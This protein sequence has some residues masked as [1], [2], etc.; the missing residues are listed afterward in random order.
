MR[1]Q[2]LEGVSPPVV[3]VAEMDPGRSAFCPW[4]VLGL[5]YLAPVIRIS[6]MW[7]DG[8]NSVE[9]SGASGLLDT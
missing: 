3:C 4:T 1:G 5:C 2:S 8:D 6:G 9:V 7:V